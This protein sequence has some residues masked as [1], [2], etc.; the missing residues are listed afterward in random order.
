VPISII[1]GERTPAPTTIEPILPIP[2]V[3]MW[4]AEVKGIW[5]FND[6]LSDEVGTNDFST[7]P[8]S[9]SY[10]QFSRYELI[11]NNIITRKGLTFEEGKNYSASNSYSYPF[12]WTMAFWWN[13]PGLVGFTRH[14]T[15]REL[16]SKV[17]PIVAIADPIAS[18]GN[19]RTLFTNA[20][21]AL[22]EIGYSKTQNAIRVYLSGNGTDITHI[23]TS[24][25]YTPGL[26]NVLITY[27]QQ[28]GRFRID[29]DGA[30]GVLH[31]A[32]TANLMTTG[33]LRIND[34]APGFVA[35]KTTQVGGILFDL[36]FTTYAA[37]DN[38]SLKGFRYGYEHITHV[39]LFDA[40]F[41][42]FG[43]AYSQPTTVSTT[44]IFVDGG[45]IFAARSNGKISKGA[46]PIW[47][48]EFSYPNMQSASLLTTSQ[49]DDTRTIKWT[50]S[51]L[52][53]KGVSVRI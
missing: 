37:T 25:P 17:A 32:P 42:Y 18:H 27:I 20:T 28:Q 8:G 41:S 3:S 39:D 47:D 33:K 15:T 5:E 46:R 44:K 12:D 19:T 26:R 24:A 23:I 40:R 7:S 43:I 38:E 30:T 52:E 29:I 11:P 51:G 13:S 31:P 10:T 9:A 16:E 53:L 22:T 34:V 49:T 4:P 6:T 50:T 2:A 36:V 48:K 45:N 21:F 35:H 14:A 1:E